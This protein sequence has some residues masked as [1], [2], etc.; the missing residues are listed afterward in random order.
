MTNLELSRHRSERLWPGC[1]NDRFFRTAPFCASAARNLSEPFLNRPRLDRSG[2][3]RAS[4]IPMRSGQVPATALS[5]PA[6]TS[7]SKECHAQASLWPSNNTGSLAMLL[8]MRRASSIVSTLAI[9][10]SAWVSRKRKQVTGRW[11]LSLYS[12]QEFARPTTAAES[13]GCF[14]RA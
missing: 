12:R 9:S 2:H 8:A 10:A 3:E 13:D 5:W 4:P 1:I 14:A 11:R 7:Q 6:T